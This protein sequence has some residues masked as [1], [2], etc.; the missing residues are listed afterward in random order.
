[1]EVT[2]TPRSWSADGR[3]LLLSADHGYLLAEPGTGASRQITVDSSEAHL[4]RQVLPDG[5]LLLDSSTAVQFRVAFAPADPRD[6]TVRFAND[7]DDE[8]WC[9]DGPMSVSPDGQRVTLQLTWRNGRIPGTERKSRARS[10]P[11][12]GLVPVELANGSLGGRLELP[13]GDQETWW[14]LADTGSGLLLRHQS[15]GRQRLVLMDPAT[16]RY[17]VVT[18]LAA[19]IW[20][21]APGAVDQPS[22]G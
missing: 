9:L 21:L 2:G 20:V 7:P 5:R 14:L 6:V 1:M 3:Y 22:D 13:S 19:G 10:G 15:A 11:P 8:C 12:Y 18:S 17:R 4:V 16:G